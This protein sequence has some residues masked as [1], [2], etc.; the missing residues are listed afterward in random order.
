MGRDDWLARRGQTRAAH[1][2]GPVEGGRCSP[3]GNASHASGAGNP[4]G[5]LSPN[6]GARE[7]GRQPIVF[8]W[9]YR[10]TSPNVGRYFGKFRRSSKAKVEHKTASL[11]TANAIFPKGVRF[12]VVVRLTRVGKKLLDDDNLAAAFKY[13]RDGVAE[14][15]GVDDGD[16]RKVTWEY[17]DEASASYAVKVEIRHGT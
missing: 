16:K 1:E 8:S 6:T 14:A 5:R 2:G 12:P 17:A 9:S 3:R 15:L 11:R 4:G 7:S 10:L 13:I